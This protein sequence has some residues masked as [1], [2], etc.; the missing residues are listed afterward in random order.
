MDLTESLAQHSSNAGAT[1]D[2][3]RPRL[4]RPTR[5]DD[6]EELAALLA[7]G[8]VLRCRDEIE[9]QLG[10]LIESES[11]GRSYPEEELAQLISDRL[12]GSAAEFGVW[13][14]FPWSGELVHLLPEEEF[15]WLR[16]DR[17]RY[18]ITPEEQERL[19]DAR[20]GVIGLSVGQSAAVTMAQE[21]VGGELRLADFDRLSVS[22]MN[23]L[24]S[25]VAGLGVS[26]AVLAARQIFE[27]NP[28]ARIELY[29]G[30]VDRDNLD[31]FLN[32]GGKLDLLVEEC[33]DLYV[34]VAVRERAR[35]LG[36]PVMMETSDRGTL[37]IERFDLEPDRP[38]FHGLA[39]PL[40]AEE[41]A[42]LSNKDKIPFVLRIL[43]EDRISSRVTASMVEIGETITTWPQLASAVVLGGGVV[44]DAARRLLLGQLSSS[45]RFYVDLE[46][47][48]ADGAAVAL[49]EPAP[50]E[51]RIS[52]EATRSPELAS[53]VPGT[54]E[55]S[56]EEIVQIVAHAI[57]APSAGNCQ[58]WRFE[59]V[60]RRLRCLQ[61]PERSFSSMDVANASVYHAIG[62]AVENMA[63][64]AAGLSLEVEIAPFPDPKDPLVVC[65][66]VFSR[67]G[68]RLE[69][70]PLL[71]QVPRRVTNRRD[72]ERAPLS[73]DEAQ[74][75]TEAAD[76]LGA[77]LQL[78][79]TAEQL[80]EAGAILGAG[81]RLRFL[82]K[83]MLTELV[84]EIRWTPE[85]VE[86][87]RDGMD[88]ATLELSRADAMALKLFASWRAM[89]L[90][91][92]LGA[93][94]ALEK[95]AR[96]SVHSASAVG[97]LTVEGIAPA[98]QLM[99]GRAMERVW[100]TATERELAFQP[101]TGLT[102]LFAKQEREGGEG[103]T[104]KELQTLS[105]LRIRYRRLFD[106]QEGHAEIMIFRV[107]KVGPPTARALR[108]RLEDVLVVR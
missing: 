50:F 103:L 92:R 6:R 20:V 74:A 76:S 30:G 100:L 22:N 106:V 38:L 12:G 11:P 51:G 24:R 75:L 21:G 3:W 81:E 79:S 95:P 57:L 94:Q 53:I 37:D 73:A 32:R 68:D 104:G 33:D 82:S 90:I 5:A 89:S 25:G 67:R 86:R 66:L 14:W 39:G 16:T 48:V 71:R 13:A 34:K 102:F 62:A 9:A 10:E 88:L 49:E 97:L 2:D 84:K 108:R 45:G 54:A 15:R 63:L 91:N 101:I 80:D 98:R 72:G 29:P 83:T 77:R 60:G 1:D 70:P 78:L 52:A 64:A 19:A 41:L 23:R 99:G 40:R 43:G 47:I 55:P 36:I 59:S 58:P 56:V 8:E 7:S 26:K 107:G 31:D 69:P 87:T 96:S 93:G 61:D 46:R 27:L 65:E 35:E 18:R 44:T 85:E 4:L 42:G 105:E 17:N 28:F